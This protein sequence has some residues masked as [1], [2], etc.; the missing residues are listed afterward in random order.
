[1]GLHEGRDARQPRQQPGQRRAALSF[2]PGI[3]Q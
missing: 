3:N 1:V 2:L